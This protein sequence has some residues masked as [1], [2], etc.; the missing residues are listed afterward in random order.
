MDVQQVA[1]I[2]RQISDGF[3]D[4]CKQC[5]QSESGLMLDLIRE[6]MYVGMDGDEQHLSPTYDD[7]PFFNEE[8]WWHHRSEDYKAWKMKITPPLAGILTNLPPRPDNVP[9]LWIDGTFHSEVNAKPNDNGINIDP[10]MGNG[11]DIVAKYGDR[12]LFP[13]PTAVEYFNIYKMLPAIREHFE[14]CGYK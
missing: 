11:P 7:D 13:G 12:L 8:G 1:D 5:L 10:G 3:E 4:A 14:K 9:N 6:Q 2:I